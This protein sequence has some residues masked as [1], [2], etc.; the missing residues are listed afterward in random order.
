MIA[1]G[2][3]AGLVLLFS[4]YFI[5]GVPADARCSDYEVKTGTCKYPGSDQNA[6][7]LEMIKECN[8]LD[9]RA[10]KCSEQEILKHLCLGMYCGSRASERPLLDP[11]VAEILAG[12]GAAFV[13]S[14]VAVKKLKGVKR[15]PNN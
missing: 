8:D 2:F 7:T 13:A 10:E 3:A 12:S 5:N 4:V 6:L 9:I 15:R 11:V 14:I 1:R